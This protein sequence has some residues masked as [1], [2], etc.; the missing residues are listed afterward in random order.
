M[1]N[2]LLLVSCI[3]IIVA[4][5]LYFFYWNR[6]LGLLCSLLL[7]VLYW[8]QEGSSCWVEIGSIHF[9]I[10]TGRILLK[11]FHYHSSNQTI[12][13]VKGQIQWRYWIRRPMTEDELY[14]K[15][16]EHQREFRVSSCRIQITLQGFEWFLYNRTAAYENII[17][18]MEESLNRNLSHSTD[19]N[20]H[21]QRLGRW[22]SAPPRGAPFPKRTL[23]VP[24]T[25]QQA[26]TWFRQQLPVLDPKELLPLG[27]QVSKGAIICGNGSTSNLFV[28][29]F[30]VCQGTFGVTKARSKCDLYRQV[31][32]LKFRNAVIR[33]A[34]NEQFID[35]MSTLGELIH[36]RVDQYPTLRAPSY[37]L[38]YRFFRR[39]WRQL[40]LYPLTLKYSLN[41]QRQRNFRASTARMHS[42]RGKVVDEETP[43]GADFSTLEYAIERKILETPMLGLS[44]LVDVVGDVPDRKSVV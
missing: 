35:P 10:L 34:E 43:V 2:Q 32:A 16:E 23:R 5:I 37:Y 41:R 1:L 26:L 38:S 39:I 22:D 12:K 40:N 9:S 8:N 21:S 31:L 33:L 25:I 44:Y 30:N 4:L 20:R 11:D 7:R 18:Q 15:G 42:K 3:C 28:A 14:V 24:A 13:I 19:R 27:I 6:F 17:S 29:E 36:D